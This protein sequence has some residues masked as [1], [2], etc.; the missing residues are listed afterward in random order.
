MI[1]ISPVDVFNFAISTKKF[2]IL[3]EILNQEN[4]HSL[5]KK[6]FIKI[7]KKTFKKQQNLLIEEGS[8]LGCY[9]NSKHKLMKYTLDDSTYVELAFEIENEEIID[10]IN[11]NKNSLSSE[12]AWYQKQVLFYD[13]EFDETNTPF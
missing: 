4:Y 8:C 11:C 2:K 12:D 13:T 10:I 3:N 9:L 5:P 7:I 6:E 1:I